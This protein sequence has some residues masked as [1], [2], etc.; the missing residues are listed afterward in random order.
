MKPFHNRRP[1]G[2]AVGLL[3]AAAALMLGTWA[4]AA[5]A[6]GGEVTL[7]VEAHDTE[8]H[9][10]AVWEDGDAI[11]DAD[12]VTA[13]VDGGQPVNLEHTGGGTYSGDLG[14][15]G[16][17][18]HEVLVTLFHADANGG[19]AEATETVT[20]GGGAGGGAT[21]TTEA[22]DTGSPTEP[23]EDDGAAAPETEEAADEDDGG[24]S[25]MVLVIILVVVGVAVVGGVIWAVKGRGQDADA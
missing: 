8:L 4:G 20:I 6:H 15:V 14:D 13:V 3:T 1:T 17:G 2:R 18:D 25:S 19:Q 10:H 11:E 16:A 23:A 5:H 9:A 22:T 12:A 21:E 7:T 24:G